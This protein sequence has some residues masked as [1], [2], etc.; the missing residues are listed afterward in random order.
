MNV[1]SKDAISATVDELRERLDG[2]YVTPED[3]HWDDARVAWNL[4]VD[5][6][7]AAVAIPESVEDIV[8]VVRYARANGYR[9]AGQSTGHNAGPLA[10]G[11]DHTVLVKTHKMRGVKIDPAAG[12][13]RVESG[14]LWM[15]VTYP[16]GEYGLAPLAGSSPDVGVAGY[17]L[18]GGISWLGRK[19]GLATNSVIAIELVN[20][21]G[22]QIRASSVENPDLF[23]AMRG[24]GGSFGIVTAIEMR[25]YPVR[26]L[27]AGWLIFPMERAEEVLNAWRDWVDTVPDEVTSVGRLLQIPPLPDVPEPLRGRRLVVVEAAMLMGADDASRLLR[28]LRKLGPEMDT[29]ATMP[30]TELQTLH[31][32]PPH[33]V[34]GMGDHMLL[35]DLTPAGIENTVQVAGAGSTSPLLSVEFRHLGGKLGRSEPG[36]GA[37]GSIDAR[38]AMFAVG[39]TMDP[40]M[41]A[42]V[43]A[44]LPVVK[45][46][47]ARYDSG[48]EYLNFA[49]HRTDVRRLWPMDTYHRLRQVKREHDPLDVFR[50]NHPV[51]PAE[52]N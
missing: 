4:A 46:A 27:Y 25:L 45:E 26:E 37:T 38:F 30:A 17:S 22:D 14:A 50:S 48:R 20:A 34:P 29:F 40:V 31:M 7:P 41:T 36:N 51:P 6:R 43:S 8:E 35:R 19:H 49:E 15:D 28:P 16:A 24:C 9:V 5:Q 42:A 12:V 18:G 13:A 44:Y 39:M 3:T 32:D 21:N 2:D 1:I 23:W 11:L 10:E 52:R 33:P 47:L